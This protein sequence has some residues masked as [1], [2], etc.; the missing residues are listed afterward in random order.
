MGEGKGSHLTLGRGGS[1][2]GSI[3]LDFPGHKISK[4]LLSIRVF[5]LRLARGSDAWVL[6][7]PSSSSFSLGLL[8]LQLWVGQGVRA[9]R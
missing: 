4:P 2:G 1:G 3:G 8:W 7:S 9:L 5:I 6:P